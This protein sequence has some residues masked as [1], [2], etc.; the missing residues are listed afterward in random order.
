MGAS[1]PVTNQS[2]KVLALEPYFTLSHRTFLEGYRRYSRH[3]VEIWDLPPRKW[4]WRMRGAAFYFAERAGALSP[5]EAPDV[6]LASDFLNLSDWKS[7]APRPFR[8]AP[9]ILYF[10]ENQATYPL[11]A[12]APA[13]FHYGWINLSSALAADRILFNSW[14]HLGEFLREIRRVLALMPDHVPTDLA[15]KV[16][17]RSS[18]F[19]V[20]ID[21]EPHDTVKAGA[22]RQASFPPVIVWNHR[23]EY[24]KDPG[25]LVDTL[26]SL[27]KDHVPFRAILCGQVSRETPPDFARAVSDLE[28]NLIH[29]GF[30]DRR[31]DYLRMLRRADVVLS[32][33]RHDFFGVAV[34]EAM[35]MGCLPVLPR[36]LSYPEIL[37]PHLHAAFLYEKRAKL[38]DFLA[39]FL[40]ALPA[41]L[42]SEIEASAARFDWRRLAPGLDRIVEE[43]VEAASPETQP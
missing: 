7:I 12:A 18:V 37:P 16:E 10:H 1:H 23:W 19:P 15:G 25:L 31:E 35:Y 8:E 3:R 24:D 34:V 21:F 11:G 41:H 9:S 2:L 28:G 26:V 43:T 17:R 5:A 29:A 36:A 13:D 30:L 32:T 14:F 27:K 22:P 40:A 42:G 38:R 39:A 6:V 20:G 33:A 4:K